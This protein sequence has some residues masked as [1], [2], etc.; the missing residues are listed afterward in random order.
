MIR[1]RTQ[2]E[3]TGNWVVD[4]TAPSASSRL[5]SCTV[6]PCRLAGPRLRTSTSTTTKTWPGWACRSPAVC[7][8][9]TFVSVTSTEYSSP[10]PEPGTGP[11]VCVTG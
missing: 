10:W 6:M 5:K 2:S 4:R 8:K 1:E 11:I 7:M 3:V 9:R